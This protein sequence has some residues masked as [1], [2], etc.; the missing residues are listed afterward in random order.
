[1]V[2]RKLS[3]IMRGFFGNLCFLYRNINIARKLAPI[4]EVREGRFVYRGMINRDLR[5]LSILIGQLNNGIGFTPIRRFLYLLFGDRLVVVAEIETVE[6]PNLVGVDLYYFNARDIA[7]QTVHEGFIGVNP[8]FRG[9]RIAGKM[10]ALAVDHFSK[11]GLNGISTR[12]SLSNEAS[13][14]SARMLGFEVAESYTDPISGHDRFY[15]VKA[16]K[17]RQP[18]G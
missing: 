4:F 15:L 17:R 3:R 16:L 1:M 12:I 9:L 8:S 13:L 2:L 6:G 10:R 14:K 11:N 5:N 7:E 18:A